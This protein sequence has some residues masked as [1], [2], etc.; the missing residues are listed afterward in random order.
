MHGVSLTPFADAL[1]FVEEICTRH[2]W[3]TVC[4]RP[5][6]RA[7]LR[8]MTTYR[9]ATR[10]APGVLLALSLVG[11]CASGDAALEEGGLSRAD[12]EAED[13]ASRADTGAPTIGERFLS[14]V[15]ACEEQ[16]EEAVLA[17]DPRTSEGVFHEESIDYVRCLEDIRY[18]L[19]WPLFETRLESADT[20]DDAVRAAWS[21]QHKFGSGFRSICRDLNSPYFF[22]HGNDV[23]SAVEARCEPM[24]AKLESYAYLNFAGMR[25]TLSDD[26]R[27]TDEDL[28]TAPEA[29]VTAFE[30]A[31]GAATNKT[32]KAAAYSALGACAFD[33]AITHWTDRALAHSEGAFSGYSDYMR[34]RRTDFLDERE[35]VETLG[36]LLA[37][38]GRDRAKPAEDRALLAAETNAHVWLGLSVLLR[39]AGDGI[40]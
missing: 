29:C 7:N 6:P 26:V 23:S 37:L 24:A 17:I 1:D 18:D 25:V 32:E 35:N 9:L 11:G 5:R 3:R 34:E 31:L 22:R 12:L 36:A 28:A 8:R 13:D 19:G 2:P 16:Y 30:S 10:L 21:S 20:D 39:E 33:D 27:W 15:L 40:F 14:G 38:A 4:A